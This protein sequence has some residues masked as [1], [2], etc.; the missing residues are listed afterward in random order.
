MKTKIR[1]L[2]RFLVALFALI[3]TQSSLGTSAAKI[4]DQKLLQN[5]YRKYDDGMLIQWGRAGGYASAT[6]FFFPTS[7]YNTDYSIAMSIEYE[8]LAEAAVLCP[9]IN[10]KGVSSF[11]GGIVFTEGGNGVHGSTW[12]FFWIAIGRWK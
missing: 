7:F 9:Y 12:H 4:Y 8:K 1:N 10:T 6:T 5:G 11:K 3:L 2:S